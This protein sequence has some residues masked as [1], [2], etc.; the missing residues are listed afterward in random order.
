MRAALQHL[1]R[2]LDFRLRRIVALFERRAERIPG[3]AARLGAS[4]G[5]AGTYQSASTPRRCRSRRPDHS[6]SAETRRPETCLR[7]R[8][9]RS[10]ATEIHPAMYSP[11]AVATTIRCPRHRRRGLAFCAPRT[12]IPPQTGEPSRPTWA[13]ALRIAVRHVDN[14]VTHPPING[15]FWSL[16]VP[17]VGA[18]NVVPPRHPLAR[19]GLRVLLDEH[20]RA[21]VQHFREARPGYC[22]GSGESRRRSCARSPRRNAQTS[23]W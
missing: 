12:P 2:N 19:I 23:R 10:S 3:D 13:K 1:S 7:T 9:G 18:A 22:A 4:A 21:G 15:T 5:C 17:P 11:D 14:R 20:E 6:R 8:P 16:W